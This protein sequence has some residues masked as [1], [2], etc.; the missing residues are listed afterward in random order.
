MSSTRTLYKQVTAVQ[1][2]LLIF[3]S[4]IS[5]WTLSCLA[6]SQYDSCSVEWNLFSTACLCIPGME[7]VQ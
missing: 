3:T 1:V 2:P 4:T 7:L 6:D 5:S